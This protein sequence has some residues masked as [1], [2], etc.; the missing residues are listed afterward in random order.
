M[1]SLVKPNVLPEWLRE[2]LLK[3]LTLLP[4]RPDG[5]RGTLEFV[6]LIHPSSQNGQPGVAQ[7]AG[8]VITHEGVAMA[9]KLL[10]AVPA[11]MTPEE[12]FQAV[13]GQLIDLLDGSAGPEL[14]RTSAKVI[15]FGILGKKQY[16]SPGKPTSSWTNS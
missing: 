3:S 2:P 15:G 6:F 13:S 14:A 4:L 1:T 16:G 7:K 12:W 5:V 8:S 10:S 11:T 9:T